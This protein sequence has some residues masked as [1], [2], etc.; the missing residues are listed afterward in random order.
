MIDIYTPHLRTTYNR[1]SFLRIG[2]LGT[3]A[4]AIAASPLYATWVQAAQTGSVDLVHDTYGGL[5]AF[6]VPGPD[7]YSI[8]QGVS[9]L[10]PGGIDTGIID[11][12]IGTIDQSA[13]YLPGF[14]AMVAGI[15]NNLAEAVHPGINGAFSSPYSNLSF[16]EKVAVLQIMDGTDA[17]KFLSGVLPGIVAFL[18][19][20]DA[21]SLD[22]ATRTLT[23]RPVAWTIS[24]YAGTAD[25][26][27]E[28]RGYF[29]GRRTAD[30][31]QREL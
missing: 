3:A 21:G 8:A 17:L 5:I 20:S 28:F 31:E 2:V 10:A 24:N 22:P 15:L 18:C 4:A 19:Y 6:V 23:G 12:L 7:S 29:Q 27:D 30:Q 1:R 25:G 13:P 11:V 26:R 16:P 9:T 14:S